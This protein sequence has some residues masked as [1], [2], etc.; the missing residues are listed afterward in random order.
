MINH[1]ALAIF[2]PSN[3]R[4][5]VHVQSVCDALDIPHLDTQLHNFNIGKQFSINLHPGAYAVAQSLRVLISYL[6][7]TQI[8]VIYEDDISLIGLQELTK[9]PL[10]RNVQFIFRKTQPQ[11]FRDTLVDLR[12]RNI[13]TMVVDTRPEHLPIFFTAILQV[14]MNE[15]RYHYHFTTFDLE[16]YDLEDFKYNEVNITSYR[17]V[18]YNSAMVRNT[19]KDIDRHYPLVAQQLLHQN[20]QMIKSAAAIMFD[21]VYAFAR[22]LHQLETMSSRN[23]MKSDDVDGGGGGAG[24]DHQPNPPYAAYYSSGGGGGGGS[25][26]H[27]HPT[28]SCSN[29]TPLANG[30]SLYNYIDSV[31]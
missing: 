4:V 2:G 29:E 11:H 23:M 9:L 5:G 22:G 1:G 6:N 15:Y 13:F 31:G 8:A 25:T 19:L 28:A 26:G 27:I 12:D 30:L 16:T 17:L 21:S 20:N 14:Q 7:W 24:Q 10:G 18:D 3:S